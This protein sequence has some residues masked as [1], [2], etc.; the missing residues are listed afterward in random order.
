MVLRIGKLLKVK[1]DPR[2]FAEHVLC[3]FNSHIHQR[4]SAHEIM[5]KNGF[6]AG[7]VK[8]IVSV[9]NSKPEQ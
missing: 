9:N 2:G 8:F 3:E 6:Q 1:H 7:S 5:M 4:P